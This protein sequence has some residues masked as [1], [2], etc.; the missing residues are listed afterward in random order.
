[1]FVPPYL[2]QQPDNIS[3]ESSALMARHDAANNKPYRGLRVKFSTFLSD[4]NHIG[5]FTTD[6]NL[7]PN[8]FFT[9]IRLTG[10]ELIHADRRT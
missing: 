10:A 2:S 7:V 4:R 9:K 3:L 8:S 5:S 1:M 6:F